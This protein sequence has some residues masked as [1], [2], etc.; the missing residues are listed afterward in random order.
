[1]LKGIAALLGA[2]LLLSLPSMASAQSGGQGHTAPAAQKQQQTRQQ[3]ATTAPARSN[4]GTW[5][6]SWGAQPPAPPKH[7]TRTGDWYRHVRACQQR[8][9][10]Y[11]ALTDTYR[12]NG[13]QNRRCTL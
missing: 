8:Y 2:S 5:N 7:W 3:P 4:Y 1:M 13:G 9:R 12:T 10:S 11:N 6:K